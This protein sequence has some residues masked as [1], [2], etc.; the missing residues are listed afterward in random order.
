MKPI[1]AA[2]H[3]KNK[4]TGKLTERE[5]QRKKEKKTKYIVIHKLAA[6]KCKKTIDTR[7]TSLELLELEHI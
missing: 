4:K 6:E 1:K 2:G 7:I 5:R 3:Q